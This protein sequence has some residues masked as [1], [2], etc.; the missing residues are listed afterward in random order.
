[1]GHYNKGANKELETE[2]IAPGWLGSVMLNF[3]D[4]DQT[5][6][7]IHAVAMGSGATHPDKKYL[8]NAGNVPRG[9]LKPQRI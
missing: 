7:F 3:D 9:S 6:Q 8:P 2:F 4:P 1:M 5:T